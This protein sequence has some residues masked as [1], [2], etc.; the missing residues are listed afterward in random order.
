MPYLICLKLPRLSL[1]LV[2]K[3]RDLAC[4]FLDDFVF[5]PPLVGEGFHGLAV[6]FHSE[7]FQVVTIVVGIGQLVGFGLRRLLADG[8]G[9]AGYA[10]ARVEGVCVFHYMK[11]SSWH[12]RGDVRRSKP[13]P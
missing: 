10:P 11:T 2:T 12:R 3:A 13:L 9:D 5:L 1:V 8:L 4:P 6:A 7:R